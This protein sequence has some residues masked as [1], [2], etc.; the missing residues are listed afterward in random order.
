MKLP[1]Q[2][3]RELV[4][5]VNEGREDKAKKI[6]EDKEPKGIEWNSY[7]LSQINEAKEVL[8]FIIDNSVGCMTSFI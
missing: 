1:N 2:E 8:L 3:F 4:K 7:T 6:Y 5:V